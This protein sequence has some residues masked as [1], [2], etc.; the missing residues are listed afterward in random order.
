ME[1]PTPKVSIPMGDWFC[2]K[3]YERA[4]RGEKGKK[5]EGT[6]GRVHRRN[7]DE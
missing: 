7:T 4:M 3:F 6:V 2:Q 1:I 5:R